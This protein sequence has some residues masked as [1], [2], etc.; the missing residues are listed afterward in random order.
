MNT[1]S[2]IHFIISLLPRVKDAKQTNIKTI[3][4]SQSNWDYCAMGTGVEVTSLGEL[5]QLCPQNIGDFSENQSCLLISCS[6]AGQFC[7]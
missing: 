1:I 5:R 2:L 6:Y 3:L 7:R 4:L